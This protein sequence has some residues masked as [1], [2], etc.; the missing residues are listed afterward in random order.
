MPLY[1][2]VTADI[3]GKKSHVSR[4]AENDDELINSFSSHD[5]FLIKFCLAANNSKRKTKTY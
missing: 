2:C 4:M 1:D 5:V 3:S